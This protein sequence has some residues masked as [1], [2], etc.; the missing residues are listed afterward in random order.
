MAGLAPP[1]AI[2]AEAVG[3]PVQAGGEPQRPVPSDAGVPGAS[4]SPAGLEDRLSALE[5]QVFD[6]SCAVRI[7]KGI[8]A[9]VKS[10]HEALHAVRV[11]R[12]PDAKSS[13]AQ[14]VP[15]HPDRPPPQKLVRAARRI[16]PDGNL[17]AAKAAWYCRMFRRAALSDRTMVYLEPEVTVDGEAVVVGGATNVAYLREALAVA[18]RSVGVENV[19]DEMRLL[20]EDGRLGE[21][22]FGAC[23]AA[24]ALTFNRPS[25]AAGVQTQLLYGE[26][27][28]LLDRDASYYLVHG[29]DGYWG[30][31]RQECV[32]TMT[33]DE[34]KRY[35]AAGRAV[36]LRDLEL[37]DRRVVRGSTL[38]IASV[39]GSAATLMH[40]DGTTFAVA[41]DD[42]RVIDGANLATERITQALTLLHRPYVF[43]AVSPL[44]MDCSG[45]VRNVSAQTGLAVGRD[46]A[47]QFLHGKLVATR[48][49]RDGIRPGDYLYFIDTSGKIFHTGLAISPTHFVHCSAP[50]VQISS[51]KKGDR[52]YSDHWD[53]TFLAAKRP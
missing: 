21:Q 35:M 46:A 24:M 2:L 10:E 23:V 42:V 28:L 43:G 25:E 48:W 26:P 50:E 40:P 8:A 29:S 31:V 49:Y 41:A 34:F 37:S 7:Y 52:L 3:V 44:G 4:V 47:Q 45:M 19:R 36:L 30:W 17:P 38:R 14:P 33:A 13:S 20:P 11:R 6:R 12:F 22:R 32:R 9:F 18:L 51:L 5:R 15:L 1:P 39:E 53:R 16:W 27:L